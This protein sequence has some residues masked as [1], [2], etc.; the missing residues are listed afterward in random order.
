[1]E[2][3]VNGALQFARID[4]NDIAGQNAFLKKRAQE[5]RARG[6]DAQDT[7]GML[8][9]SPEQRQEA[10]MRTLEIGQAAGLIQMPGQSKAVSWQTQQVTG[11]DGRPALIQVNPQTGETRPIE[12]YMP[13]PRSGEVIETTPDGG[14][15]ITRGV[16]ATSG[17]GMSRSTRGK[18]EQ[19]LVTFREQT[20]MLDQIDADFDPDAL[21]YLGKLSNAFTAVKEK[22]GI[23]LSEEESARQQSII[24]FTNGIEQLFNAYRKEITGAAA[25]V[26]ELDRLKASMINKDLSPTQFKAAYDQF[27]NQIRQGMALYSSMLENGISPETAGKAVDEQFKANKPEQSDNRA[28]E[29]L[30]DE[31]LLRQLTQ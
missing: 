14:V 15:T 5:I 20:Q 17:S 27:A 9:L 29:A 18:I 2:S 13:P 1:L 21:T 24:R 22:A 6:G 28:I 26:Q 11:P 19:K 12:G 31:E 25:S 8:T 30:S 23:E 7:L 3:L 10:V 4:P 16:G